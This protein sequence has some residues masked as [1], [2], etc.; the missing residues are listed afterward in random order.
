[1]KE[2][3]CYTNDVYESIKEL[4]SQ[5]YILKNENED[6][7]RQMKNLN[8]NFKKVLQKM[9]E[10]D[11]K[12]FKSERNILKKTKLNYSDDYEFIGL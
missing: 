12:Y 7:K 11:S 3:N 6:I 8:F 2:I 1:M 4:D 5:I 10:Y 9:I